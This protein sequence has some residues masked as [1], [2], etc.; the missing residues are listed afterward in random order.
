MQLPSAELTAPTPIATTIAEVHPAATV[1]SVDG[2]AADLDQ[3]SSLHR[4]EELWISRLDELGARAIGGLTHLRKLVIHDLRLSD[5]RAF[6][7]LAALDTLAIAGSPALKSLIGL[8]SLTGLR[9][10]ILF[11]NCNYRSLDPLAS[12]RTLEVLCLEGGFSKPLRLA[13]LAPLADLRELRRVRL[14]SVRVEDR[15]L[16]PIH[17]LHRLREVFIAK[18]FPPAEFHALAAALPELRGEHIDSFRAAG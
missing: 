8:G 10:L 15:S 3:L 7:S 12:L 1:A 4:L 18:A 14:A 5:L 11:D 2:R 13:T 17:G 9:T 16:R 6:A